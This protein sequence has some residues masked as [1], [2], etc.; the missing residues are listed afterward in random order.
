MAPEEFRAFRNRAL[1]Y[2]V[3]GRLLYRRSR[4]RMPLVWVLDGEEERKEAIRR[5]HDELAAH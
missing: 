5:I 2:H 3:E 4:K 1:Q